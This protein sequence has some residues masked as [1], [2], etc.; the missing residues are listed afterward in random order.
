MRRTNNIN[1]FIEEGEQKTDF[2]DMMSEVQEEIEEHDAEDAVIS[3]APELR[4]L[5]ENIDKAT[6]TWVNAT[7]QLESAIRKDNSAQTVLGNAVDTISGKVDTINKHI[8]NV[9][10]EAPTKLQ[11]SVKVAD[12]DWKTIQEMFDK[13]HKWMTGQMRKHIHE[14]NEMFA[15]ELR[16]AQNR[17]K[18]YDGTYLGH[19]V[20]YFVWFFFVLGIV[21]FG[22]A[23][24]LILDNH[25]HW[26]K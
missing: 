7:L 22:L 24:F 8:D 17:Y 20:Q 11:V 14:V 5:S 15:D 19:Y 26:T 2:D 21:I 3:R 23:I 18:E 25:Y 6:N 12:E 16:R 13:E 4:Q 1:K 9:L 10:K